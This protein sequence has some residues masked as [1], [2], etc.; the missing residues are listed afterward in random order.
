MT[1]SRPKASAGDVGSPAALI[2]SRL[3]PAA[4]TTA[5][6]GAKRFGGDEAAARGIVDSAVPE[7]QVL[8]SAVEL[9]ASQAGKLGGTLSAIK[10]RMYAP[11]LAALR[12]SAANRLLPAS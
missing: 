3:T 2:Q 6:V 8:A 1:S 9:A 5:M 12:D 4:A 11:A 7:D 10:E